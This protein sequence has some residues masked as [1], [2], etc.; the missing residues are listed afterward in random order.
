LRYVFFSPLESSPLKRCQIWG[1]RGLFFSHKTFLARLG[2][3]AAPSNFKPGIGPG[4]DS[5][6]QF[7]T[8]TPGLCGWIR[9]ATRPVSGLDPFRLPLLTA[10]NLPVFAPVNPLRFTVWL[11]PWVTELPSRQWTISFRFSPP[12]KL[13]RR[14]RQYL[15]GDSSYFFAPAI[16]CPLCVG[17]DC[18]PGK[19]FCTAWDLTLANCLVLSLLFSCT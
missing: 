1:W 5:S 12:G 19:L 3:R 4:L 18:F 6:L 10:N 17:H 8:A 7:L 16:L 2:K 13:S 15:L 14:E 11:D 9:F